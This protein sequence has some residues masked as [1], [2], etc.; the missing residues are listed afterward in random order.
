MLVSNHP[1][2]R[3]FPAFP[4]ERM[5]R[6]L[7]RWE[8][9]QLR[10]SPP[11]SRVS[12]SWPARFP[13]GSLASALKH[14]S[15]RENDGLSGSSARYP[16]SAISESYCCPN[17]GRI[18]FRFRAPDPCGLRAAFCS[19]GP[20][21]TLR[22]ATS[23]VRVVNCPHPQRTLLRQLLRKPRQ[24][25]IAVNINDQH[26]LRGAVDAAQKAQTPI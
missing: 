9:I 14:A 19:H 3:A 21:P 12:N 24:A 23:R 8:K 16:A 20:T 25:I 26:D 10:N 13:C 2:E 15:L 17:A 11:R 1:P 4:P 22:R 7:P 5:G 6:R 18:A